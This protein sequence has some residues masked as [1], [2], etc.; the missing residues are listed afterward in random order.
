MEQLVSPYAKLQVEHEAVAPVPLAD[1]LPGP[2]GL[3]PVP[4][5]R[6]RRR[7]RHHP[8]ERGRRR[9]CLGAAAA[10]E[11]RGDDV[12][13]DVPGLAV[14]L[15]DAYP[16]RRGCLAVHRQ[17]LAQRHV[18]RL[19]PAAAHRGLPHAEP[20]VAAA[21]PLLRR[22]ARPSPLPI[23]AAWVVDPG[24]SSDSPSMVTQY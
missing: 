22:H 12:A 19:L 9:H 18:E 16:R 10:A 21:L 2:P 1:G 14:A 7:R 20:A 6:P 8:E 17:P 3:L 24:Q 23:T 15:P 13:G 4:S 5:L 11:R